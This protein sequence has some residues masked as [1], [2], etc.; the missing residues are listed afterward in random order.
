MYLFHF[1]KTNH[2]KQNITLERRKIIMKSLWKS[3]CLAATFSIIKEIV[4]KF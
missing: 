2:M 1:Y 4:H 3:A